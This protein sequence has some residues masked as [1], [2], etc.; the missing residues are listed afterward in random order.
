MWLIVPSCFNELWQNIFATSIGFAYHFR[1]ALQCNDFLSTK[2]IPSDRIHQHNR[3]GITGENV[4]LFRRAFNASP[5][6]HRRRFTMNVGL[7]ARHSAISRCTGSRTAGQAVVRLRRTLAS[8]QVRSAGKN[9]APHG[10][11]S[12]II[13]PHIFIPKLR[14]KF[15]PTFLSPPVSNCAPWR[16][17]RTHLH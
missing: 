8:G 13:A 5:S 1:I 15:L 2:Q 17:Q 9:Q 14:S 10:S 4:A 3:A 7:D 12:H 6:S 11:I 16:Q